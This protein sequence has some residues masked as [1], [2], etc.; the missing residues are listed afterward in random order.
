MK[1]TKASIFLGVLSILTAGCT[2]LSFGEKTAGSDTYLQGGAIAVDDRTDT[3]YVLH[4]ATKTT[5][6]DAGTD[7]GATTTSIDAIFAVSPDGTKIDK[8]ED[9]AG[10]NDI[11]I[12]FP[13]SGIMVMSELNGKDRLQ[14]FDN[15]SFSEK[16]SSQLDIRYHGTRMSPS[17]KWVAVADNTSDKAPIHIINSATLETQVVPHNGEWLE[18]MWMHNSDELLAIVFYDQNTMNPSARI[19]S[20]AMSSVVMG[21]FKPDLMTGYWPA[22]KLDI[23]LPLTASDFLFSFTWVGISPDDKYAVF[24]VRKSDGK[25]NFTYQLLVVDT[26]TGNI[27]TIDNAKG[28]VGFTPDSSTIVSYRDVNTPDGTDQELLLIDMATLTPD[29]V[30]VPLQGGI[31]YFVSHAGN[32]IVV[33]STNGAQRLVLHDVDQNK[34]TQ[35]AGPGIGLNE[36]VSRTAKN[37]LWLVDSQA[38]FK[39]DMLQAQFETVPTTFA[40]THINLLPKKDELVLAGNNDGKLYFF[41]PDSQQVTAEAALPMP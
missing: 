28:P 1:L 12:L 9:M 8:V 15:Q 17:R 4:R 31:T 33:A 24:P 35:M 27:N 18:A 11:R 22:P 30:S 2:G 16:T 10:R 19:L 23:A 37:E 34:T 20:W 32:Y 3:S 13:E 38:L 14:L 26:A 36:F 39:L 6:A 40:P 29:A 21:D 25:D 7:A 5:D 41:S